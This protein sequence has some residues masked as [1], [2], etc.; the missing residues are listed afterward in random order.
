MIA[1]A[2]LNASGKID[3]SNAMLKKAELVAESLKM[4]HNEVLEEAKK[5][6]KDYL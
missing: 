6:L 3:E 1:A 2:R 4:N 5:L